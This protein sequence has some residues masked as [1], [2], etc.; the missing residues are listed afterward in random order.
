MPLPLSFTVIWTMEANARHSMRIQP[1]FSV[2]SRAFFTRLPIASAIQLRS[3]KN[4]VSPLPDRQ[5]SFPSCFARNR[6]CFLTL[7]TISDTFSRDL[8]NTIVP[9][10]SFVIFKRF[11]TSP[12]I[13][14]SSCSESL[15]NSSTAPCSSA[16]PCISPI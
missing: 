14:S 10:S 15:E 16:S 13:R 8:S 4:V 9:A 7:S 5:I 11:C 1:P 12:S 6:K 2:W 3:H